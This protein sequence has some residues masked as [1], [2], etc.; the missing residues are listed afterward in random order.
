MDDWDELPTFTRDRSVARGALSP[1]IQQP[2][3]RRN[4]NDENKTDVIHEE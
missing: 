3:T 1:S 4:N 2:M